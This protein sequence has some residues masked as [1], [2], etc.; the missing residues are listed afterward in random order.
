MDRVADGQ[1]PGRSGTNVNRSF[2]IDQIPVYVKA[3]AIVPMQP[4]MLH[5][6]EKP[7]DPLDPDGVAAQAGIAFQ[8]HGL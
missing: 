1:A 8:L 3:G 4:A 5:T 6:G 2:S 7:V